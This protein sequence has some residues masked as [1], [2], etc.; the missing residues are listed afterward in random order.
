MTSLTTSEIARYES[1]KQRITKGA[2]TV[3]DVMDALAELKRDK[4]YR[5]EFPNFPACAQSFGLGISQAK[6]LVSASEIRAELQNSH[7]GGLDKDPEI[8]ES[9]KG[10]S[11]K[12]LNSL[13]KIPKEKRLETISKIVHTKGAITES[14]VKQEAAKLNHKPTQPVTPGLEKYNEPQQKIIN[15]YL[16][17]KTKWNSVP[18]ITPRSMM[19]HLIKALA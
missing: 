8:I 9:I 19:D 13:S 14:A 11:A 2:P 6:L 15:C 18:P 7:H 12:A 3:L 17:N 5:H 10:A 4:L 1:L 16:E